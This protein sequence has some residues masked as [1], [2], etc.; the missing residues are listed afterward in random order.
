MPRDLATLYDHLFR[1]LDLLRESKNVELEA[2]IKRAA[3]VRQTAQAV[4]EAAKLE[5]AVHRLKKSSSLD[6]LFP[7]LKQLGVSG[8]QLGAGDGKK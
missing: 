1:S 6:G 4:I 3:A 5:V 2:N 7:D 8:K